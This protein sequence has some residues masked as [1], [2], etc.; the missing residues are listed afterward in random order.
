MQLERYYVTGRK[1]RKNYTLWYLVLILLCIVVYITLNPHIKIE[2]PSGPEDSL[3]D[4]E[5]DDSEHPD[6]IRY[7]IKINGE[8]PPD[9]R[10]LATSS[11]FIYQVRDTIIITGQSITI[12]EFSDWPIPFHISA[13]QTRTKYWMLYRIK[14]SKGTFKAKEPIEQIGDD[15]ST[16]IMAP[17]TIKITKTIKKNRLKNFI[18]KNLLQQK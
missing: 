9:S 12:V 17:S 11:L 7:D 1:P 5:V 3:H 8:L 14:T 6:K 15:R 13:T 16:K 18:E 4:Y 2:F 10:I